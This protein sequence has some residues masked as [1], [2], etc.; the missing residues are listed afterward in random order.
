M[1]G[2]F[3]LSGVEDDEEHKKMVKT[4]QGGGGSAIRKLSDRTLKYWLLKDSSTVGGR[5]VK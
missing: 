2:A 4:V 5:K 3:L 1:L